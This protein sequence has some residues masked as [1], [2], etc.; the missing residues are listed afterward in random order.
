VNAHWLK[1]VLQMSFVTD[2]AL[3]CMRNFQAL[4]QVGLYY[5]TYAR[6]TVCPELRLS[7]RYMLS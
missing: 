7:C 6:S 2:T 1:L 3:R 4:E 5:P